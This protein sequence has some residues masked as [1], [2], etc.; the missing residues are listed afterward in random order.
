MTT[1]D[2]HIRLLAFCAVDKANW[3]D[4]ELGQ[5][6]ADERAES[7]YEC[8]VEILTKEALRE[9][10]QQKP[11]TAA[12]FLVAQVAPPVGLRAWLKNSQRDSAADGAP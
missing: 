3:H 9:A 4:S 7:P 12:P 1:L 2:D 8:A 11:V 5:F 10:P 6:I